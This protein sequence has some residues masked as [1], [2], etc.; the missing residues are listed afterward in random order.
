MYSLGVSPL[1]LQTA[2]SGKEGKI[3]VMAQKLT[4][5]LGRK[6]LCNQLQITFL[7]L[8]IFLLD[9]ERKLTEQQSSKPELFTTSCAFFYK[10]SYFNKLRRSSFIILMTT[11]H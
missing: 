5:I 6:E 7:N 8:L 11:Q 1:Q 4:V 3:K 10:N 2:I 9:H